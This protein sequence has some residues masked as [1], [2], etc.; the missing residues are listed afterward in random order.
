MSYER[1]SQ[2]ILHVTAFN[3][4]NINTNNIFIS[5]SFKELT[6]NNT[7][8]TPTQPYLNTMTTPVCF[9]YVWIDGNNNVRSKNRVLYVHE[10]LVKFASDKRTAATIEPINYFG[11][12]KWNYDGSSTNQAEVATS[13][14]ILVLN[15]LIGL[16]KY[17]LITLI[18]FLC[19][20]MWIHF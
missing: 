18:R 16:E 9:E 2:I 11:V 5:I 12:S 14:I 19:K 3:E 4:L 7:N 13:E 1:S 20:L 6:F 10:G 17:Y 8:A 15:I